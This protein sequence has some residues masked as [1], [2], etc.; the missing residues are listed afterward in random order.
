MYEQILDI[1]VKL[2]HTKAQIIRR[3][4]RKIELEQH[5]NDP[6]ISELD[7]LRI[8]ADIIDFNSGEGMLELALAGAEKELNTIKTIMAELEP[9]RKYSELPLLEA[10][11]AAQ[12]DEWREE[13]KNRIENYL[14]TQ[15]TIPEDQLRAMRNH[16][17]FETQLVPHIK[18]VTFALEKQN[19]KLDM[20]KNHNV[21]LLEMKKNDT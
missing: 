1:Q 4:I 15:G 19:D 12:Q 16:P 8:E 21:M 7:K 20:L 9:Y 18:K 14:I 6:N 3:K 2:E 10:T 5:Y 17:D 11:E 13:F